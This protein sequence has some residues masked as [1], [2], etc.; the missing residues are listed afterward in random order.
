[1]EDDGFRLN[2]ILGAD[3]V[4]ELLPVKTPLVIEGDNITSIILKSVKKAKIEI[5]D[6]DVLII[7][8]KIVATSEG[9]NITYDS[10]KPSV[11][12]R[13]LARKYGLEP[14]FI[15]LV[16]TEAD[17]IYGGVHRALL[18]L[19][20]D[21]LIANAGIDHKNAPPNSA[22]LWSVNPN[23]TARELWKK[24]SKKTGK[25]IGLILI[26]SH[27]NPM[28]VGTVGFA[29]GI[30]GIKPLKDFRGTLD[31]YDR[32]VLITRINVVDDLAAAGHLLM[33]ETRELTPLVIA[34]GAPVEV[35][36]DYSPDDV[37]I[38]KEDCMFMNVFL[39]GKMIKGQ[40]K[41]K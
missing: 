14:A 4:M 16:L 19:R 40:K 20:G 24:I 22:C 8:D 28:R 9:R 32:P 31:L 25:K 11:R 21:I 38:A 12:A 6:D 29:L 2:V 5:K 39:R 33:G 26:D 27:I 34:R 41:L 36:D 23:K 35:T 15:E 30:A 18:T 13:R 37:V 3:L 10:V 1:M 7:A 17:E